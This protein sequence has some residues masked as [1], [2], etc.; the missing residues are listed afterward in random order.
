MKSKDR[1]LTWTRTL[2]LFVALVLVSLALILLS[3]GRQMQ[4]VESVASQVFTPIQRAVRDVTGTV[5]GW[6][7]TLRRMNELEGENK[8]LRESLDSVTAENAELQLLKIEND[9][10]RAMVKF[11]GERPE[12]KGIQADVIGGDPSSTMEI[13]TIDKGTEDGIASGM[14]VVSP[15]GIL[16]GQTKEVKVNR[17]TVLLIVDISSSIAVATQNNLVPGVLEGR[18][19]QQ[20]RL[21]MRHIPRDEKLEEGDILLTTGIGGVFPKGLIAGQIY[22]VRQS[23]VGTEKEAEA[24]PLAQLNALEHVLVITNGPGR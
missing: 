3:Q 6:V 15:G 23:D 20:G 21:L 22:S 16:V 19:Q 17:A 7:E 11:Q 4:P 24:Y 10:L 1:P 5:G 8:K 13:L 14:A 12:I 9:N 18:S 2:Y